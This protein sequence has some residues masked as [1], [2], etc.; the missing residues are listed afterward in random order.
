MSDSNPRVP[1]QMSS[2]RARL[3]PLNGKPLMVH[4]VM[5]V[6][7]WPFD[8]PMPRG[9]IPPPHG[10]P[11]PV[12][13]VGNY[14]WVEYGMRVGMPRVMQ[15]LAARGIRASTF[16]NAQC[17]DVYP[18]CAD[19][20]LKADWEFVGH[21]WF[22]KSLA[23]EDNEIEVIEK[24]LA[25]LEQLTGKRTRGWFGP[26]VGETAHTPD[27]LKQR[28]IEWLSDWM[29]DDLPTWMKTRHGPMIAMPYTMELN[30]VPIWVVQGQSSDELLLRLQAT[31]ETFDHELASNP[32]VLTLGLHPHLVGVPHRASYFAKC[33]DLLLAR[34]DT[35]FVTGSDI[36]DWFVKE[37]AGPSFE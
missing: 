7:Y 16:M 33:L 29:V 17:A 21:G 18:S 4:V 37:D 8:Q 25:R 26:G 13:D 36:A 35:V 28:G 20:M 24:S 32:K 6:E 15:I 3:A 11:G 10:R 34:N 9:V 5:N 22:Q 30:D 19:A 23:T 27:L 2:E 1:Y 14:S 31:L 12:P